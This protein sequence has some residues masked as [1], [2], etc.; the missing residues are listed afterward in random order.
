MLADNW[1]AQKYKQCNTVFFLMP[2]SKNPCY[3]E[4]VCLNE[5]MNQ[6]G[7]NNDIQL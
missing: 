7:F 1:M 5:K 6:T 3:D 2:H 4:T